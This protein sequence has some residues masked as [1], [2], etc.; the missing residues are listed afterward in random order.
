M[1][2]RIFGVK[3]VYDVVDNALAYDATKSSVVMIVS[4][5]NTQVFGVISNIIV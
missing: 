2:A 3:W 1:G 4:V 5:W